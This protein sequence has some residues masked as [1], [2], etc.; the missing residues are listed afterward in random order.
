MSWL[1]RN[2]KSSGACA[3]DLALKHLKQQGLQLLARNYAGPRG[4]IDLIMSDGDA[5]V[6]IEVRLRRNRQFTSAAESVNSAKQARLW[7]T[8]QHYLQQENLVDKVPCRFDVV[9]LNSLEA[10]TSIEWISNAFHF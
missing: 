6:F 3:E 5:L 7:A 4:E 8:A 1:K 9:A 10:N 2:N